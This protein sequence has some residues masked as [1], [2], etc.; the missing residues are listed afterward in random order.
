M[1]GPL[2]GFFPSSLEVTSLA[3]ALQHVGTMFPHLD[4]VNGRCVKMAL[5]HAKRAVKVHTTMTLDDAASIVLYTMEEE[6][7]ETSLYYVLNAALRSQDRAQV[8]PWRDFIWLLMHAL[9]KLP[10]ASEQTVFRGAKSTPAQLHLDIDPSTGLPETGFEFTWSAFS[11][12]ACTQGVMAGFVGTDGPRTMYTIQLIEP[13]ARKVVAFSLYPQEDELLLPPNTG[14]EVVSSFDA[15]HG[16]TMVQCKQTETVDAILDLAPA[17][18]EVSDPTNEE[19]QLAWAMAESLKI[20]PTAGGGGMEGGGSG[21]AEQQMAVMREQMAMMQQQLAAQQQ[22]AE[23]EAARRRQAEE[24]ERARREAVERA[25][26]EA[27]E[28]QAAAAARRQAEEEAAARERAARER[29]AAEAAARR[30]AEE[31]AA[32]RRQEEAK[33]RQAEEEAARR[34]QAEEEAAA[35]ER[36]ARERAAAEAA[37]RRQADEEAARRRQAE[38]AARERAAGGEEARRKA[39]REYSGR[40]DEEMGDRLESAIIGKKGDATILALITP[41]SARRKDEVRC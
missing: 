35:R 3:V 23:E 34:R 1:R 33:R 20:A 5:R 37:A 4:G 16:L 2:R 41:A 10:V 31:E 21:A 22:V 29:A 28:A 26:R 18:V 15:G 30:Q 6:P 11:S 36:A 7:R 9:K 25:A 13:I 24:A 38:A 17:P 8:R 27:A 40:P 19:T 14:F 39:G 32:R 12:T